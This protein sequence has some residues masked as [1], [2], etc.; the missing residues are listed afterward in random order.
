MYTH[1]IKEILEI[2]AQSFNRRGYHAYCKGKLSLYL[3]NWASRHEDVS[4]SGSI[5]PPFLTS[6]LDGVSDQLH[7]TA[8]LPPRKEHPEP[9]G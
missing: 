3:I 9:F 4:G 5:A 1:A 2:P 6:A 7:F 8:A